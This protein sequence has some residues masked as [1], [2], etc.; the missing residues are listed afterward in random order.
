VGI[1]SRPRR[2]FRAR[3]PRGVTPIIA[4][5]LLVA[6]TVVLSAVLYL[7]VDGVARGPSQTPLG[8][9]FGFG[10]PA[11][12][13]S[14][15][16]SPGCPA[17]TECYGLGVAT[18][19]DGLVGRDLLFAARTPSGT[20]LPTSGWTVSLIGTSGQLLNATWVGGATCA[21]SSCASVIQGGDMF[22]IDTG[23]SSSLQ[24]DVVLGVGVGSF[25]G[26]VSS[27]ALPR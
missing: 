26:E 17:S 3:P 1:V 16:S 9:T 5:I 10:P 8:S 27:L 7:L 24:S 22:V 25:G 13:T 12:V 21:G 11:N 14:S 2:A 6:I 23:G 15:S 4:T 18:A 20:T 19:G